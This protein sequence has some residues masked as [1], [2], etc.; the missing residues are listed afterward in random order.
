LSIK[1][2]KAQDALAIFIVQPQKLSAFT[3]LTACGD[4]YWLSLLL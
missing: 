1:I 2:A 3:T 4:G